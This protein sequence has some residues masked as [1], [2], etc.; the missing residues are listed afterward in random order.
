MLPMIRLASLIVFG[1]RAGETA[2]SGEAV[3]ATSSTDA[4]STDAKT[5]AIRS[6]HEMADGDL[7][8][9]EATYTV[10]AHNRESKDEPPDARRAGP[11]ASYATA[12]WLRAAF[13][14]LD[15]E[16]HDAVEDG[17]LVVLHTTM[18]GRQTGPFIAYGPDARPEMVFPP[19]GRRFAVT[20]T[21]WFRV[22]DG[23]VAEHWANRDDLA[24]GEQLGWTPPTP[25]YLA[26]MLLARRRARRT[27]TE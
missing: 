22:S 27:A 21:H 25:L 7:A 10:D 23:K 16:V 1:T 4:G 3:T 20:Q 18:S 14:E 15:W 24:M 2:P 17:D 19:R 26:R 6:L 5:L 9:F 8:D 13:S 12:L 11:A